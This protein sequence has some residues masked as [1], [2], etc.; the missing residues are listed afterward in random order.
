ME[1]PIGPIPPRVAAWTPS[2]VSIPKQCRTVRMKLPFTYTVKCSGYECGLGTAYRRGD[3][4]FAACCLLRHVMNVV[5]SGTLLRRKEIYI[6]FF[7]DVILGCASSP[8]G[9]IVVWLLGTYLHVFKCPIV[10]VA[11]LLRN[12][13]VMQ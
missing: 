7:M 2:P 9:T 12:L 3:R 13:S 1:F 8:R 11:K 5:I 6:D 4:G 10:N